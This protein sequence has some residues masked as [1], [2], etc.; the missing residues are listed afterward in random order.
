MI[1]KLNIVM[2]LLVFTLFSVSVYAGSEA[3]I[4]FDKDPD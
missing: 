4:G 3:R 2:I 1:R